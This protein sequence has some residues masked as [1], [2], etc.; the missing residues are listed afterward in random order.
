MKIFPTPDCL[1]IK[2][3]NRLVDKTPPYRIA[4]C[5]NLCRI[6]AIENVLNFAKSKAAEIPGLKKELAEAMQ[7]ISNVK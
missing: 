5:I 6:C 7:D 1:C 3:R 4:M 2:C